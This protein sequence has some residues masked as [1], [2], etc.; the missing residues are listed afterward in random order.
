MAGG[1]NKVILIGTCG[2]DPE[3]R[4]GANGSAITTLRLAT[5][6]S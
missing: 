2:A 1:V 6:E 4:Y 5:N 3:T